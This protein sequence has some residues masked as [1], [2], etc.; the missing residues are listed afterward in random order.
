VTLLKGIPLKHFELTGTCVVDP[1]PRHGMTMTWLPL[2]GLDE[3]VTEFRMDVAD[4]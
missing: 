1:A 4:K 3:P 2:D